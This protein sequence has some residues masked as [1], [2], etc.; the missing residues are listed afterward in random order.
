MAMLQAIEKRRAYRA[1]GPQEI[2]TQI[3]ERLVEAA[4][5][6]PSSANNQPWR[7]VTVTEKQQ[8]DALK[9][10]LSKG[11]YW[12]LEA[13]AIVAF[14]TSAE[15]S[16]SVGGRDLAFFELGMAAMAY[17]L[18]AVE[19]GLHVHPIVGFNADQAKQ[20][21]GIDER[22]V[23]EILMVVGYPGDIGKLNEKHHQV[24][25]SERNRKP[26]DQISS[27]DKWDGKLV[28]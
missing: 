18:Q 3:L 17:Q 10:T 7:M 9:Q 23:L 21:L 24:E 19:E 4:H 15:W 5:T 2:D 1:I 20:V 27:W 22:F 13:P 11:N 26:L 28:P 25:L 6:A 8:L 12:A 16:M 14:V